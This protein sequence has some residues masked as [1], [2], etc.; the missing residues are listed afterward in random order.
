[1]SGLVA[2]LKCNDFSEDFAPSIT[3]P[4]PTTEKTGSS[5]TSVRFCYIEGVTFSDTAA[6]LATTGSLRT[7]C[8]LALKENV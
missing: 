3:R 8:R 6:C 2:W 4:T 5:E 7:F 1:M